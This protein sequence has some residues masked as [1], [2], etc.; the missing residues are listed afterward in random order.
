MVTKRERKRIS[1]FDIGYHTVERYEG[2]KGERWRDNK[3][4]K[5]VSTPPE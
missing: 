1:E 4:G 2:E 5:F 3:T